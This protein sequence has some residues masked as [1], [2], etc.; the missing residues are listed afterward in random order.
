MVDIRHHDKFKVVGSDKK[1]PAPNG[2]KVMAAVA[3]LHVNKQRKEWNNSYKWLASFSIK[4]VKKRWQKSCAGNGFCPIC[5][6]DKDKHAPATRPLL[7][8]LNLK[9]IR[10]SPPSGSPAAAPTLA[11]SPTPGGRTA[12]ADEA[13]ALGLAGSAAAPSGLVATVAEEF[14]SDDDLC[15]DGDKS[16]V[17]F[18]NSSISCKS[19]NNVAFHPFCNHAVVEAILLISVCP[20]PTIKFDHDV[21]TIVPL[22]LSSRCIVLSKKLMSLIYS[23]FASSFLPGSSC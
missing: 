10:I 5:H 6:R 11:A 20:V 8:E 14:D 9:P 13:S 2:S 4:S 19:N 23:M 3:S 1:A 16:G 7:A 12:V 22:V 18:G 15:W 17:E 21:L